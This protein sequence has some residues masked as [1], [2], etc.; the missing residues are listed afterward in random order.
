MFGS[1]TSEQCKK[2]LRNKNQ[3]NYRKKQKTKHSAVMN[4]TCKQDNN[5]TKC[6]ELGRMDQICIH[7]GANF[8]MEERDQCSN[9]TF[10]SYSVCCAGGK[11]SLPPLLRPPPYL[12][13]LYTSQN[14]EANTFHRNVRSY[15]SLLAC[16]SLG[17]M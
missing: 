8:W 11:V 17:L 14:S 1:E 2:R 10:P 5:R 3:A 4:P 13:N 15:N 6:H 16:T 7:C 9:Q 12:M